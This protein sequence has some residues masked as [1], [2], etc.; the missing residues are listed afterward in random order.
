MEA[1]AYFILWA[2]LFFLMMRFGCGAHILGH[3]HDTKAGKQD[4]K[5]SEI[6]SQLRWL[7]PETDTDPVC[8][9][10]VQ[11]ASAKSTV[12]DGQVYYFCSRDCRERFEA[13][14]STYLTAVTDKPHNHKEQAHA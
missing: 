12:H 3:G 9:K 6:S 5:S 14:P 8:M 7:A 13:A 4:Q 10:T 11:T 2:G 1:L